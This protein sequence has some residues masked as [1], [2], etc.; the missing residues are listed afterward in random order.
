MKEVRYFEYLNGVKYVVED[1]AEECTGTMDIF[2]AISKDEFNSRF[3][4]NGGWLVD[5]NQVFLENG[6]ICLND[7]WNGE[8]YTIK[9]DGKE[10]TIRPVYKENGEDIE[11]VGYEVW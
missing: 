8:V 10:I 6:I 2:E 1:E 4:D 7:E 11:V 3:P 9:K 5:W